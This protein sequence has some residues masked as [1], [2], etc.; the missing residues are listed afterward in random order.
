M[1]PDFLLQLFIAG[2]TIIGTGVAVYVAIRS[3]ITTALIT[4]RNAHASAIRAHERIDNHIGIYADSD[5][6][7]AIHGH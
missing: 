1:T 3:D 5:M 4:A 6:K 7:G 2:G